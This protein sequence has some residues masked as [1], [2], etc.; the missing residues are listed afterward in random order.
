M[1]ST[2]RVAYVIGFSAPP[3]LQL[4]ECITLLRERDWNSY[5]IL[6]PTAATWVDADHL[7]KVSEHPV[8]VMPR[9]P[10]EPDP[11]PDAD[12]VLAAPITFN[13]LCKWAAGIS[14][15]LA[16]GVLNESLGL[17]APV[18]TAPCVKQALRSHPAYQPGV[19]R[20]QEAGVTILDPDAC[21]SRG[22]DGLAVLDWPSVVASIT[23]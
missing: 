22:P 12:A 19:A 7:S 5:V 9:S 15:T 13:S 14:D 10:S 8:R 3:V 16:L 23:Q 11:L 2:R 18:T 4:D 17:P 20:L 1:M 6:S 21:V